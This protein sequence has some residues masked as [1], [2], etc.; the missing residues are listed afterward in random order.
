MILPQWKLFFGENNFSA[1]VNHAMSENYFAESR[2]QFPLLK[3]D[4]CPDE[5]VFFLL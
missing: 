5:I 4:F 2:D 1:S 3:S